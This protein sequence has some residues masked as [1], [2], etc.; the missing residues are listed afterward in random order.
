LID[1]H[2]AEALIITCGHIFR[3][4]AGKGRIRV[5]LFGG[6]AT[7][8]VEGQLIS[9]DL[10]RDIGLVSITPGVAI[11]PV[12]VAPAGHRLDRGAGV[13]S[14]GCD[15]GGEPRV[16]DSRITAI[17]KYLGPPNIET[18]GQPVDGRSGGGLYSGDG[19][20]IGVCN[21]ADPADNEGIFASLPTIHWELDRV[22]QRRIYEAETPPPMLAANAAPR[23]IVEPPITRSDDR[24]PAARVP[25]LA[26]QLAGANGTVIPALSAA[27]ED[28]EVICIVRSGSGSQRNE[29]LFVLDRPSRDLLDRLA[30][31]SRSQEALSQVALQT[32]RG[33]PEPNRAAPPRGVETNDRGEVVRAQSADR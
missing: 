29:Q 9:Y 30:H 5:D 33:R 3:T 28:T 19:Y 8:T 25:D 16:Q 1:Q 11:Q 4:S 31:E 2:G 23:T 22:G 6:P 21:A 7:R 12:R 10:E 26:L 14:V 17:D 27:E 24:S 13:F 32:S 18:S 20:L 15:K